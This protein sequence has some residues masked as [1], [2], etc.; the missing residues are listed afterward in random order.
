MV[1]NHRSN[2]NGTKPE[3]MTYTAQQVHVSIYC[4]M[5]FTVITASSYNLRSDVNQFSL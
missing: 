1:E 4:E 3:Y 2:Y 5:T